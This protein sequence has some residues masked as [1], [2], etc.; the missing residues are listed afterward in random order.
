MCLT[1]EAG[2][3]LISMRSFLSQVGDLL[4]AVPYIGIVQ[5]WGQEEIEQHDHCK[6]IASDIKGRH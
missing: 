2:D 1:K 6:R 3:W 4:G 5:D